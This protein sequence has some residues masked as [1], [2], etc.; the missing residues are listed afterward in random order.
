MQRIGGGGP[1]S[2]LDGV[3]SHSRMLNH[4]GQF[5]VGQQ[6][7]VTVTDM[8]KQKI[9]TKDFGRNSNATQSINS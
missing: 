3:S 7:P 5:M 4:G 6:S 1:L 9:L 2:E 8:Q